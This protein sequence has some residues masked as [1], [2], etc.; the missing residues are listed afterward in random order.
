M[1]NVLALEKVVS[2]FEQNQPMFTKSEIVGAVIFWSVFLLIVV[3]IALAVIIPRRKRARMVKLDCFD[4]PVDSKKVLQI[5]LY[6]HQE[7]TVLKGDFFAAP[8]V[9]KEGYSFGGW[10]YDTA[11]T[12]PY[13]N[14]KL[15]K[16][17]ILY[18]KWV[19]SN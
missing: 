11:C 1:L 7:I 8:L 14:K 17:V 12:V 10:F 3:G 15:T 2:R 9:A 13:L 18:P 6:G 19:K 5:T 4:N 16:N